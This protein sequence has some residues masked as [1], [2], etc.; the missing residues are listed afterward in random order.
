MEEVSLEDGESEEAEG[1][2]TG[3]HGLEATWG[4]LKTAESSLEDLEVA[5]TRFFLLFASCVLFF[6]G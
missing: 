3:L 4:C 5:E 1:R 6:V 2:L